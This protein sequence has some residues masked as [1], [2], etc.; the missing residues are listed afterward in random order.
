MSGPVRPS[1][2][3]VLRVIANVRK[4]VPGCILCFCT[5]TGQSTPKIQ[6][7][8]DHWFEVDE[9]TGDEINARVT[10]RTI[11]FRQFN[12][13]E[14]N[15]SW[16]P[17]RMFHGI[18]ALCDFVRPFVADTDLIVR[19]RTDHWF[20]FDPGYFDEL[21]QTAKSGAYVAR[22]GTGFDWFAITSFKTFRSVWVFDSLKQYNAEVEQAW[23][24]EALVQ[25]RVRIPISYY[26]KRRVDEYIV[27][28]HTNQ[29]FP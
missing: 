26:D 25:K 6:A 10:A 19:V 9:P 2:E 29:R 8:V 16:P 4:Q 7:A 5:W 21:Y 13:A 11:Q 27:R 1:E 23:N 14:E 3:S 17:Y 12:L 15:W 20:T 18:G 24:T 28:G 22:E